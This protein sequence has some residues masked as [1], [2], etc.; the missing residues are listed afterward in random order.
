[1]KTT[2]AV[3]QEKIEIQGDGI[4]STS[5]NPLITES[6]LKENSEEERELRKNVKQVMEV[7]VGL[8]KYRVDIEKEPA[9]KRQRVQEYFEKQDK[10]K[11][12]SV[13]SEQPDHLENI[14]AITIE[15][16][17]QNANNKSIIE[18]L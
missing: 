1:M 4:S 9:T 5:K 15:I 11:A 7:I 16:K 12:S 8:L 2:P 6:A 18:E 17:A 10:I 3:T 14:E 13:S